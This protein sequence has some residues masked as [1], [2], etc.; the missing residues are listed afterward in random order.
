M[1]LGRSGLKVSQLGLGTLAFGKA[2]WRGWALSPA[3]SIPMILEAFEL[4]INFV[5]TANYYSDGASEEVVGEAARHFGDREKLVLATKV[6]RPMGTGPN[7]RGLSR[8]HILASVDASLRRLQTDYIDLLQIHRWDYETPIEETLSALNDVV[9]AGKVRYLGACTV[10]A[11]Q[12]AKANFIARAHGWEEFVSLQCH[13]NLV[14]RENER[15]AMPYC[16]DAGIGVLAYSPL[17]RG[18]LSKGKASWE[19]KATPRGQADHLNDVYYGRDD[20]VVADRVQEVA[21][22]K[23]CAAAHVA[24][25]WTLRKPPVVSA[26]VGPSRV[27]HLRDLVEGLRTTLGDDEVRYLEEAYR[28]KENNMM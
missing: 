9:R 26:I 7:E 18:L 3:D 2:G 12:L 25:A 5:D 23:G 10:F 16:A 19:E 6:C 4:G 21:A 22:A 13:L 24:L 15:E 14:Y 11:W 27:E 1:N 28:P 17:A 8:K 20:Y